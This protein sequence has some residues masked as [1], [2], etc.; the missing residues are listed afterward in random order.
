MKATERDQ[1]T[2]EF[3][4]PP[5]RLMREGWLPAVLRFC[6]RLAG[7]ICGVAFGLCLVWCIVSAICAAALLAHWAFPGL[8]ILRGVFAQTPLMSAAAACTLCCGC[9]V[10]ARALCDAGNWFFDKADER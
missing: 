9:A 5:P 6:L 10:M 7:G 4:P 2:D 3:T 8:G 1:E